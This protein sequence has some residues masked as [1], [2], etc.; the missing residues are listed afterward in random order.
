M[1]PSSGRGVSVGYGHPGS[2]I[3]LPTISPDEPFQ[4]ARRHGFGVRFHDCD[5]SRTIRPP[6]RSLSQPVHSHI[7]R[8]GIIHTMT[9]YTSASNE[10]IPSGIV[11]EYT[12]ESSNI[13]ALS[14]YDPTV[15]P[16]LS[17]GLLRNSKH[18][19]NIHGIAFAENDTGGNSVC[20]ARLR[21]PFRLTA[22]RYSAR[23]PIIGTQISLDF[24]AKVNQ[25]EFG[26]NLTDGLNPFLLVRTSRST[27]LMDTKLNFDPITGVKSMSSELAYE[28]LPENPGPKSAGNQVHA[29]QNPFDYSQVAT[30]DS[31]G[32]FF[33]YDLN[34]DSTQLRACGDPSYVA[35]QDDLSTWRHILW[36]RDSNTLLVANRRQLGYHDVREPTAKI[37]H[38]VRLANNQVRIYDVAR[39]PLSE[40]EN[41]VLTS[42]SIMWTDDRMPGSRILLEWDHFVDTKDT[43]MKIDVTP[44]KDNTVAMVTLYSQL[45]PL[46][47]V[48][49]FSH[50]NGMPISA[51]DPYYY[52]TGPDTVAH[53]IACIP[54][55]SRIQKRFRP[56]TKKRGPFGRWVKVDGDVV[57]Q[58]VATDDKEDNQEQLEE[59][60]GKDNEEDGDE[61]EDEEEDEE[62]DEG[63]GD[64]GDGDEVEDE[65]DG[66]EQGKKEDNTEE[67]PNFLCTLKLSRD[68][69][70][71]RQLLSSGK[72]ARVNIRGEEKPDDQESEVEDILPLNPPKA[73]VPDDYSKG[74]DPSEVFLYDFRSTYHTLF[75][76][77]PVSDDGLPED[78]VAQYA[79]KLGKGINQLFSEGKRQVHSLGEIAAPEHALVNLNELS[80]MV[81]ELQKHY[82]K[83]KINIFPLSHGLQTLFDHQTV[84]SVADID[85]Y[86]KSFWVDSIDAD[87]VS[88]ESIQRKRLLT[89][90]IAVHL[91]LSCMGVH[92]SPGKQEQNVF[93]ADLENYTDCKIKTKKLSQSVD[94][95]LNEWEDGQSTKDYEWHKLGTI[96]EK[97]KDMMHDFS[98]VPPPPSESQSFFSF[99]Q[100]VF[101]SSS[102]SMPASISQPASLGK[103]PRPSASQK[104]KKKR[105]D[106]F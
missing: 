37:T 98:T 7:E 11:N 4:T 17:T 22:G 32:S 88:P 57:M 84:K 89:T 93:L 50:H 78:L 28:I 75:P 42:Q 72:Y 20:V 9:H 94:L 2:A 41:F 86:L 12:H 53:T 1:W 59:A 104:R 76:S 80:N 35:G 79:K 10:M 95:L 55:E 3:Y 64:D 6:V 40:H 52:S 91:T 23:V 66:G 18:R 99:S 81:S 69:G 25:V 26:T 33:V 73:I 71:F 87:N 106:G 54:L 49:Q 56:R 47:I 102:S 105:N 62:E 68:Y 14:G 44:I 61:D 74:H 46:N 38:S 101:P 97:P 36:G 5:L 43:S 48:Y 31:M 90:M 96:K 19:E 27:M 60:E 82:E 24:D 16:L 8:K 67:I 39:S 29:T 21:L 65:G 63:D 13:L 85:R 51:D 83:S 92:T 30:I 58:G 15:G 103:R 70:L 34:D 100:P 77:L 45:L